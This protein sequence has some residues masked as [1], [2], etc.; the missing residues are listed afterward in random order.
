MEKSLYGQYLHALPLSW[1]PETGF[2][3]SSSPYEA[4]P[5][6][7]APPP[8]AP[9]PPPLAP[10]PL[11]PPPLAPLAL[12]AHIFEMFSFFKYSTANIQIICGYRSGYKFISGHWLHINQIHKKPK[13][14][15][16]KH[17]H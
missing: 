9:P 3:F 15:Q 4:G 16:V 11:A 8:L 1:G 7:L 10:P 12:P 17:L 2:L 6:L 13:N 14:Y 5:P